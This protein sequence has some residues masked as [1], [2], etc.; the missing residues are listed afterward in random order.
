VSGEKFCL[1]CGAPL[2]LYA[3][4]LN[5]NN[6]ASPCVPECANCGSRSYDVP[7]NKIKELTAQRDELLAALRQI[8]MQGVSDQHRPTEERLFEKL[9]I[10]RKALEKYHA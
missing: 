1:Q 5:P 8:T 2:I 10:A 4:P 7:G 6:A 3:V 9:D